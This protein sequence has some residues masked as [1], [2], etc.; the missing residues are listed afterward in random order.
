MLLFKQSISHRF[1]PA[2]IAEQNAANEVFTQRIASWPLH[3]LKSE[4]Y[5]LTGL[6]AFW[7]DKR[8]P[9][10][11]VAGFTSAEP[12]CVLPDHLLREG[13]GVLLSRIDP[14][15]EQ[16]CEGTVT[17]VTPWTLYISFESKFERLDEGTWRLD[18]RNSNIAASRMTQAV[19]AMH[20]DCASQDTN[21]YVDSAGRIRETILRGT[22]LRS[23]LLQGFRPPPETIDM[24]NSEVSPWLGFDESLEDVNSE[25]ANVAFDD[26]AQKSGIFNED[27]FIHSWARRY[28]RP[29]PIVMDGDPPMLDLNEAQVRAVALMI[30]ERLSLVQGPPGTGKTKTIVEAVRLL[31]HHFQ[32]PHPLLVC[33]YT[34]VAVDNLVEGLAD[35][36]VRPL[37]IGTGRLKPEQ[38][39]FMLERQMQCH[40]LWPD[41]HALENRI[42]RIEEDMLRL[43]EQIHA[44][45]QWLE[46]HDAS[47]RQ[48]L[49]HKERLQ[50]MRMA[51]ET[52][53]QQRYTVLW[54]KKC[55]ERKI[56]RD[57]IDAADVS[58]H[59][60]LVGDHKQLPPVILS[61]RAFAAGFSVSLFE[62]LIEE[63]NVPNIMLNVQYRMHPT[64]S[65]FPSSEFYNFELRD[66]TVDAAGRVHPHLVPPSSL[67]ISHLA[68]SA[69]DIV[70]GT[71]P[72]SDANPP[73]V[74]FI[75]HSGLESSR[76][77]SRVNYSE[78][79]IVASL[80]EDL[81]LKNPDLTGDEIGII[82]PYAAQISLITRMFSQENKYTARFNEVLGERRAAQ[83]ARIEIKTVDG[84]E[85]RQ[86]EVIVF[87]TVR[88]NPRGYI[89]FLADRRRL[90][91]GLTRAKRGL[92]V[93]GG[94]E[95]LK[96]AKTKSSEVS[97]VAAS[98]GAESW[99]RYIQWLNEQGLV[100]DLTGNARAEM[101]LNRN[102]VALRATQPLA[103]Q[104][105]TQ[106]G[107][108]KKLLFAS[109]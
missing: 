11:P 45:Q 87:S 76:D 75:N 78:A 13:M 29:D 88:N 36:G 61:G 33:T 103:V 105:S 43:R 52:K 97:G 86:K 50:R 4:G 20:D 30:G 63:G 12:G 7:L 35:V 73:S 98:G 69:G 57:C 92:F 48:G 89:G 59:V 40:A 66:G 64:I 16:A 18:I 22:Y 67:Y 14:F 71:L 56:T 1:L 85:G 80:V 28:S 27:Q 62:R 21:R 55:L 19:N 82:A 23:E 37:R 24:T 2:I 91:V 34:N 54:R 3:K 15:R 39:K 101:L 84:F 102:L 79:N 77:R 74:I 17:Q 107:A 108:Y 93:I 42:E 26:S 70:G 6:S 44:E 72:S 60:S 100:L 104:A 94:M 65:Q 109:R 8:H 51:R 31:K 99:R 38:E 90:N 49:A 95:T 68:T 106:D 81:L 58:R 5:T 32:V 10:G 53:E 9:S 47:S 83:V 96:V 25:L 41:V 46:K